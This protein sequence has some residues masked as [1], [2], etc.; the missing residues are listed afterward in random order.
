MDA[1]DSEYR[2]KIVG[3]RRPCSGGFEQTDNLLRLV[4]EFRGDKPFIPK[5]VYRFKSFEEA[6]EWTWKMITR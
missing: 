3:R 1:L 6:E 5:G 4:I 2:M